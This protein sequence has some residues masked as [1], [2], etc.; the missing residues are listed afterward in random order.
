MTD[1]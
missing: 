1:W